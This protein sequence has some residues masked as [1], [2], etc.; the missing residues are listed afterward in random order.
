[1]LITEI[2]IINYHKIEK[3]NE[4][5]ITSRHPV[6][7]EQDLDCLLDQGY[8]SI[9]FKSFCEKSILPE[10]PIIIT[11]DDAY[12]SF[13]NWALELLL[14]KQM[15][16]IVYVPVNF[17]GKTNNWD[18]QFLNKKFMHMNAD[19]L[20]EANKYGF[21]IGSHSLTHRFLNILNSNSL[22]NEVAESRKKLETI[23][24]DKV[25]SISYPFGRF[26]KR[27]L[28]EAIQFYQFGVQLLDSAPVQKSLSEMALKRINIY[29]FNKQKDFINK[30]NYHLN[31]YVQIKNRIA[32]LGSWATI[33]NQ[34]IKK[35]YD[36]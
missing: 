5:G 3:K 6:D 13:Y 2:P 23:I 25:Y 14:K 35:N 7:F 26:N 20:K 36:G 27:V 11:F 21:E 28:E 15:T 12:S 34:S 17:I 18:A 1:M 19:Q 22:H 8:S 30:L 29:R 33:L 4:F 31:N 24:D 16:C 9:T 10:K 32:H